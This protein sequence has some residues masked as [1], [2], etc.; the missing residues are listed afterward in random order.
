[1]AQACLSVPL[2]TQLSP[3]GGS[4]SSLTFVPSNWRWF[5]LVRFHLLGQGAHWGNL[6]R[7]VE[8]G[9]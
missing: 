1:M 4:D 2:E 9:S 8:F 5:F 3:L 6:G 7:S